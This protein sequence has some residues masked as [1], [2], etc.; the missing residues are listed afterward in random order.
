MQGHVLDGDVR[1]RQRVVQRRGEV[2][3]GRRR[4]RRAEAAG[5]G[6]LIPLRVVERRGDVRRQRRH[7]GLVEQ[8]EHRR[9][10]EALDD[11]AAVPD[12]LDAAQRP[13]RPEDLALQDL[14]RPRPPAQERLPAL[15]RVAR[16]RERVEEQHLDAPP[17]GAVE[18]AARGK[19][20]RVVADE[21]VAGA[22]QRRQL[23]EGAVLERSAR[24]PRDQQPRGVARLRRRLR[25][26]LLGQDVVEVAQGDAR[27]RAAH[28]VLRA[29]RS[30]RAC[31]A[32]HLLAAQPQY[33]WRYSSSRRLSA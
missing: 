10:A 25:D 16:A 5:V 17:G 28:A 8:R 22:E 7:P 13:V 30:R 23:V 11:P 31:H 4:R 27:A 32:S 15:A 9:P 2:Q 3:A 12:R 26:Q 21:H 29:R 14:L 20:A 1:R 24:A 19:H 6:R 33:G 18:E